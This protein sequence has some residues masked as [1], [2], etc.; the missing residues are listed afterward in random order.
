MNCY[1]TFVENIFNYY[2]GGP[3]SPT[4]HIFPNSPIAKSILISQNRGF[5]VI[6]RHIK[7]CLN[8]NIYS[9]LNPNQ[10]KEISNTQL[11]PKIDS[12]KSKSRQYKFRLIWKHE[13]FHIQRVRGD[14]FSQIN[15]SSVQEESS[16]GWNPQF[17]CFFA[18]CLLRNIPCRYPSTPRPSSL[19]PLPRTSLRLIEFESDSDSQATV[20]RSDQ[21]CPWCKY[22]E[23]VMCSFHKLDY[24]TLQRKPFW[25][26]QKYWTLLIL[27]NTKKINVFSRKLTLFFTVLLYFMHKVE[28]F[29]QWE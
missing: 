4:V 27:S 14:V 22:H 6:R 26:R 23:L 17:V 25:W 18:P 19:T 8:I 2:E 13:V 9:I 20:T 28:S 7:F 15:S 21:N 10:H 3:Y 16:F 29:I 12:Q 11:S 5:I 24:V 1:S